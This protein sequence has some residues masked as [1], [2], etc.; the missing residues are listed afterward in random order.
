MFKLSLIMLC[1]S[2]FFFTFSVDRQLTFSWK[3]YIWLGHNKMTRKKYIFHVIFV[4]TS[5]N[6]WTFCCLDSHAQSEISL[7]KLFSSKLHIKH[8]IA[9]NVLIGFDWAASVFST[10]LRLKHCCVIQAVS[11]LYFSVM[12]SLYGPL[13]RFR[14]WSVAIQDVVTR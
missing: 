12:L 3:H 14:Q 11:S 10:S 8:H 2:E 6:K 7:V 5:H 1:H 13:S 9:Y 4:L